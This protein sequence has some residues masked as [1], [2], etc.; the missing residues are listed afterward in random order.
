[1]KRLLVI[2]LIT[3]ICSMS[4][5]AQ[6]G[7][8]GEK[9]PFGNK[10]GGLFKEKPPITTSW[11]DVDTKNIKPAD[12]GNNVQYNCL[13]QMPKHESGGYILKPGFYEMTNMS[14]CLK[15]GA[16][17][18][19]KGNGYLY[20]PSL[21]PMEEVVDALLQGFNEDM[22]RNQA[23]DREVVATLLSVPQKDMQQLLWAIIAKA[24]YKNFP[25]K[26]TAIAVKYLTPQQLVKLSNISSVAK[27]ALMKEVT[28][29]SPAMRFVVEAENNI[30]NLVDQ[31]VESFEDFERV[32]V[33]AGVLPDISGPNTE[34]GLW[35][36][37]SE[38]GPLGE[39]TYYVRYLPLGYSQ[40]HIQIFV[41]DNVL[42]V[43]YNAVGDIAVP[44][45]TGA[46]RLAQTNVPIGK[47]TGKGAD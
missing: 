36:E 26:L 8:I 7:K 23:P 31:G 28:N 32:A 47:C 22:I 37:I 34:R 29:A 12:F 24:N 17:A 5:M 1:M 41:P 9:L 35:S 21:G 25:K 10:K 27:E 42:Q 40:T 39:Q 3:G 11:E 45:N 16:H 19:S 33:L 13:S 30:R 2:F 4:S 14:F 43:A 38:K 46:Q 18:V 20:A 44:A 6:L 15:A